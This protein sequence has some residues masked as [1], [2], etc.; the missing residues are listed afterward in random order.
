MWL[1]VEWWDSVSLQWLVMSVFGIIF[2]AAHPFLRSKR[3]LL[4]ESGSKTQYKKE[5]N[6]RNR[7]VALTP[8]SRRL[9]EGTLFLSSLSVDVGAW[10]TIEDNRFQPVKRMKI[11]E[12]GS[13]AKLLLERVNPDDDMGCIVENDLII[14]A[15]EAVVDKAVKQSGTEA[16]PGSME[17]M[18]NA[19]VEDIQ[20]P[21][22]YDA[23]DMPRLLVRDRASPSDAAIP[24]EASLLVGADG[25]RSKVRNVSDIHTVGWE[26]DQ[27]AIVAN[28]NL[29]DDY[30]PTIAWQ[31]FTDTG[32]IALLPLGPKK[33]STTWSTTKA[34]AK[35][36]MNLDD[37]TF[38]EPAHR[39]SGLVPS[40]VA[41]VKLALPK[42]SQSF[43]PPK[44]L[45]VDSNTRACFPLLFRHSSFYHAPR[46]ALVGYVFFCSTKFHPLAVDSQ[47]SVTSHFRDAA[48]RI[49]PLSGQG[50]NMG[51]GDAASLAKHL[52]EALSEGADIASPRFL[53]AYTS[54]RQRSV[55]PMAA[56][57]EFLQALY[58]PDATLGTLEPPSRS[59]LARLRLLS[60]TL[61][62]SDAVLSI[63]GL[64]LDLVDSSHLVKPP[65]N[66]PGE[67]NCPGR[68]SAHSGGQLGA[69]IQDDGQIH[70]LLERPPEG[71][72]TWRWHCAAL[73]AA[74]HQRT[75]HDSVPAVSGKEIR[76]N[77]QSLHP[78]ITRSDDLHALSA[79]VLKVD[80]ITAFRDFHARIGIERAVWEKALSHH[81]FWVCNTEAF[82]YESAQNAAF[83]RNRLERRTALVARE[84]AR[85]KVDIAALN[86][87]R[88]SE[89]LEE[90]GAGYTSF[91][92]GRLKTERLDAGVTFAIRNDIVGRLPCLP[93]GISDHRIG[94]RGR[95]LT[96]I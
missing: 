95:L 26:H 89:Q 24:I 73:S 47:T 5:P 77:R 33:C 53:R 1:V 36:L 51:F 18:H 16:Y 57:V 82:P 58:S 67:R 14:S 88:F 64:G 15:L 31:R 19:V 74:G 37:K 22:S 29:P 4:L 6:L 12:V 96:W 68:S 91:W 39:P 71:R 38:N 63:R 84:L 66:H 90:V 17:V 94:L 65:A 61:G 44:I 41:A 35:R 85:Y 28:L 48:H 42:S 11:Y 45:G 62:L 9:F 13:N 7:V 8:I 55:V 2:E 87:T 34:E 46:V 93:Q 70:L 75:P 40:I 21:K 25:F 81:G 50:V 52:N 76:H 3:F 83:S 60:S 80:R 23:V 72:A 10:K 92:S 54:D 79:P 59:V 56:F 78:L 30:D 43:T 69:R 86:E 27:M 20:L 49:L 32:P